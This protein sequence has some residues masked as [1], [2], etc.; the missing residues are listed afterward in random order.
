MSEDTIKKKRWR[1]PK[2]RTAMTAAERQ[3]DKRKRDAQKYEYYVIDKNEL[4]YSLCQ[5]QRLAI[6]LAGLNRAMARLA[7]SPDDK[8]ELVTRAKRFVY[9]DLL[10]IEQQI[11]SAKSSIN[12]NEYDLKRFS[13]LS[14][15][16]DFFDEDE[17]Q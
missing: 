3:A 13:N 10:K 14:K 16:S 7:C 6:N 1:P 12:F 8:S 5:I 11:Q 15:I 4:I 2:Y 17:K 9:R